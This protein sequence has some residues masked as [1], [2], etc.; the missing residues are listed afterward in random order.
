MNKS[1]LRYKDVE[2]VLYHKAE[3]WDQIFSIEIW[4]EAYYFGHGFDVTPED[5]VLDIGAHIGLFTI[6]AAKLGARVFAFEPVREHFDLLQKNIQENRLKEVT[7]TKMAIDIKRDKVKMI[8]PSKEVVERNTGKSR[9]AKNTPSQ[10]YEEIVHTMKLEDAINMCNQY[11]P[12]K[13]IYLKMDIEGAEYPI[14][15][16]LA[17]EYMDQVDRISM[18]F[19]FSVDAGVH[20]EHYLQL[21]GFTTFLDWSHGAQGRLQA[22]RPNEQDNN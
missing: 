22:R 3:K 6:L 13:K 7:P 4:E 11:S 19:H 16:T 1:E 18:E 15:Y 5:V 20:L 21:C 14:L 2:A 10:H 8:V 17:K 9:I 12:T